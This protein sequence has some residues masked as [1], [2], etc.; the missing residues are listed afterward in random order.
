RPEPTQPGH[1]GHREPARRH[2]RGLREP[3]RGDA[4]AAVYPCPEGLL[5]GHERGQPEHRRL[6]GATPRGLDESGEVRGTA[7]RIHRG[8]QH[9]TGGGA[10]RHDREALEG[11]GG[12]LDRPV[13]G[14]ARETTTRPLHAVTLALV[15]DDGD[16]G[17]AGR[18]EVSADRLEERHPGHAHHGLGHRE[19][20]LTQAT[21]LAGG[22]DAAHKRRRGCHGSSPSSSRSDRI[23]RSPGQHGSPWRAGSGVSHTCCM[24]AARA[25]AM[26][27]ARESPTK[28]VSAG[29]IPS[30]CTA[31]KKMRGSGLLSPTRA[32]STM[33]LKSRVNSALSHTVERLP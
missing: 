9:A 11:G 2:E 20:R 3:Q 17:D 24:P 29:S 10:P 16:A 1:S 15:D 31:W 30:S 14:D 32:E 23:T 33:T 27:R 22:D 19:S 18:G 8:D 28:T 12:G 26:S 13:E 7:P 4:T 25:P 21:A 6:L 5:V